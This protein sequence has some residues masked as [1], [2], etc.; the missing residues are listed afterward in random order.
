LRAY[1][2]LAIRGG[3]VVIG[4]VGGCCW[5]FF[6]GIG[7][8]V[9]WFAVMRLLLRIKSVYYFFFVL[10]QNITYTSKHN[11][12]TKK[13]DHNQ[14]ALQ[15]KKKMQQASKKKNQFFVYKQKNRPYRSNADV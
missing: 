3:V 5:E 4:V 7:F 12:R 10:S 13:H 6:M 9:V 14:K 2:K 15:Q 8:A 1:G 11:K